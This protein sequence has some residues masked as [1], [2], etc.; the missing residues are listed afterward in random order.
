MKW[1]TRM[2]NSAS[3]V[4]GTMAARATAPT[5]ASPGFVQG[6]GGVVAQ[7][8]WLPTLW[9]REILC[10]GGALREVMIGQVGPLLPKM[11]AGRFAAAQQAG[12]AALATRD[13]IWDWR[14]SDGDVVWNE[15]LTTLFGYDQ[16][17]SSAQWW[18]EHIHP[19]D[20]QRIDHSIHAVIEDGGHAWSAEYRFLR[21]DGQYAD[22]LDRGTVLRGPA[23][24]ARRRRCHRPR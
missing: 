4:R 18:L 9:V 15:A 22:V 23:G 2:A 14:M 19:D 21:A 24:V 7:H 6:I 17:Q 1:L 16:L 10:E 20:R 11:M 12:L 13:A 3:R 8:P 5:R